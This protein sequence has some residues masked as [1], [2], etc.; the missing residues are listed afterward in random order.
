MTLT[1]IDQVNPNGYYTYQ[2][3]LTWEFPERVELYRGKPYELSPA[4]NRRHQEISVKLLGRMFNYFENS[5]CHLF[6]APFDVRLPIPSKNGKP[7][8]VVQP[9]LCIICDE[10][11]LDQQGCNGAPDLVVEILSPGNPKR[12]V[13]E[14]F[15][16]YEE[17]GVLEYWVVQPSEGL[18]TVFILN[19]EGKFIGLQP[20]TALD[21]LT[22]STFPELT[23]DLG[24]ILMN[25]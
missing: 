5:P 10:G 23:I 25:E 13:R 11:K 14:K 1:S 7:D 18:V 12:E 8:T 20:L 9:D 17:A 21:A 2:D 22:S 15:L 4:P 24:E 3:Y 19:D 16:L 6:S